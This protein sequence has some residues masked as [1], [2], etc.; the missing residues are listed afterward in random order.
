MPD[1]QDTQYSPDLE[2]IA[3]EEALQEQ[4]EAIQ[5]KEQQ[6]QQKAETESTPTSTL[7]LISVL[8]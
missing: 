1:Y 8:T 3:E 5:L 2:R 6:E 4:V 7:C